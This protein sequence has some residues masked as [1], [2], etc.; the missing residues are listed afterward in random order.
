MECISPTD[1]KQWIYDRNRGRQSSLVLEEIDEDVED[2]TAVKERRD[3]DNFQLPELNEI[4]KARLASCME[5]IRNV[6]GDSFSDKRIVDVVMLNDF[7][8]T[9]SLDMLLNSTT[10]Q[11]A[12]KPKVTEVE[13]GMFDV[14]V[15]ECFTI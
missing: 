1:S 14:T 9:K 13:K 5:E 15:R 6:T 10:T 4:D 11:P 2:D 3:S 12:K 8:F 7:D